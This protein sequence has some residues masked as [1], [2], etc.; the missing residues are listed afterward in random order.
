VIPVDVAAIVFVITN[1]LLYLLWCWRERAIRTMRQIHAE[2]L[3]IER[4]SAQKWKRRTRL[5]AKALART[6]EVQS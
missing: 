4:A 6:R 3:R 5:L 1:G 2:Q